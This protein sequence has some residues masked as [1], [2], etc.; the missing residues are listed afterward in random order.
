[1]NENERNEL[2]CREKKLL[3]NPKQ[4][5]RPKC[6]IQKN[7]KGRCLPM[8]ARQKSDRPGMKRLALVYWNRPEKRSRTQKPPYRNRICQWR[9]CCCPKKMRTAMRCR[10]NRI[11]RRKS[12][13]QKKYWPELYWRVVK[14]LSVLKRWRPKARTMNRCRTGGC[15]VCRWAGTF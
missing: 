5:K 6:W 14:I 10:W 1:M 8:K 12:L 15:R 9:I 4:K 11:C 3:R 7:R 2:I 13:P